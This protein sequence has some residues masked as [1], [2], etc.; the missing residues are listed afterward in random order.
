MP[1]HHLT[2]LEILGYFISEQGF[3][4]VYSRKM[5]LKIKDTVYLINLDDYP[6]IWTH[7]TALYANKDLVTFYNFGVEF[8][9]KK[10]R[11]LLVTNI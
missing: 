6:N 10:L 5:S 8:I 2:N 4:G 7:W 1:S 9:Q 11:K 3:L